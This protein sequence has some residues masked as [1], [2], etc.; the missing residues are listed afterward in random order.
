MLDNHI[1]NINKGKKQQTKETN[2]KTKETNSLLITTGAKSAS[3]GKHVDTPFKVDVTNDLSTL[4]KF[5][6]PEKNRGIINKEEEH[7]KTMLL[8]HIEVQFIKKHVPSVC[9]KSF[10]SLVKLLGRSVIIEIWSKSGNY[11]FGSQILEEVYLFSAPALRIYF[12]G[13]VFG[14]DV[15]S[16]EPDITS[17]PCGWV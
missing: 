13:F 3:G 16:H 6:E 8:I 15:N 2:R 17:A 12:S 14:D 9:T 7:C 1:Y 5:A 4:V 10:C 11:K